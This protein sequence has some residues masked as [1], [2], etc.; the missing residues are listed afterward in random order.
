MLLKDTQYT[1]GSKQT[2]LT[3]VVS[4][5]EGE[6][7]ELLCPLILL[8]Q[9]KTL[10]SNTNTPNTVTITIHI[11]KFKT[12]IRNT[13]YTSKEICYNKH[14]YTDREKRKHLLKNFS[15]RNT[16]ALHHWGFRDIN[17]QKPQKN[18]IHKGQTSEL[19]KLLPQCRTCNTNDEELVALTSPCTTEDGEL[20]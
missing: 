2:S 18:S 1:K 12:K 14:L 3:T 15:L 17:P 9:H 10:N 13:S 4:K 19:V 20:V 8:N 16:T 6:E 11:E 5:K 7:L